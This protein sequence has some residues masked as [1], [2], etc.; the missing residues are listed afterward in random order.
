MRFFLRAEGLQTLLHNQYDIKHIQ[1]DNWMVW[2]L[3]I[4]DAEHH[5][6]QGVIIQLSHDS[7]R[8][9]WAFWQIWG[10]DGREKN[11]WFEDEKVNIGVYVICIYIYTYIYMILYVVQDTCPELAIILRNVTWASGFQAT[12][13]H[14]SFQ[15]I[16]KRPHLK[17]L[18]IFEKLFFFHSLV[19]TILWQQLSTK[20]WQLHLHGFHETV[21]SCIRRFFK[22]FL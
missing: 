7:H 3:K 9:W 8:L 13:R 19:V 2:R 6:V 15:N 17:T 18:A 12:K 22:H 5:L 21:V 20:K 4:A 1:W 11:W 16:W 10:S 14:H